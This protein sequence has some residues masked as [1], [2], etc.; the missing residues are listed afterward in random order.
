MN[1]HRCV[2]SS[3]K[4]ILFSIKLNLLKFILHRFGSLGNPVLKKNLKCLNEANRFSQKQMT[5]FL[6]IN[7]STNSNYESGERE[8]PVE[9]FI[10]DFFLGHFLVK[11]KGH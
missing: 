4:Y 8:V 2:F 10:K 11:L 3:Y 7:R 9:Y 5:S 6:G 1:L